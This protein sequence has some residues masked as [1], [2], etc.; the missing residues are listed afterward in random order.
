MSISV[1]AYVLYL[2]AYRVRAHNCC[3]MQSVA[4]MFF[5]IRSR[6]VLI[7]RCIPVGT[8]GQSAFQWRGLHVSKYISKPILCLQLFPVD[9]KS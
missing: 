1:H 3:T 6:S 8:R 2:C 4:N 5:I 7:G 9:T